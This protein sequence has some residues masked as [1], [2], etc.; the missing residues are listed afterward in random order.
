MAALEAAAVFRVAVPDHSDAGSTGAVVSS[1]AP[2][3]TTE[4]PDHID[5]E[6]PVP[7]AEAVPAVNKTSV[8][9]AAAAQ[10]S[11]TLYSGCFEA[12]RPL[13]TTDFYTRCSIKLWSQSRARTRARC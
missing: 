1:T 10:G 5:D 6:E 2:A 4:I 9:V 8:A 7:A 13:G 3:T 12:L 11:R